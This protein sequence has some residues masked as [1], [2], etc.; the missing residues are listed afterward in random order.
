MHAL[1]DKWK[2][3]FFT[4]CNIKGRLC[5][6]FDNCKL[7]YPEKVEIFTKIYL[8]TFKGWMLHRSIKRNI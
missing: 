2:S 6:D 5:W 4:A 3:F 1:G 8:D 7:I